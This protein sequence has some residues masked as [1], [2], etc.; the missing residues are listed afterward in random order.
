MAEIGRLLTAMVTPFAAD[1]SVDYQQARALA[2]ALI[3]SGSDGLIVAGTTGEAPTLSHEERL[4][5]FREV[6]EELGDRGAVV[7]GTGNYNTAESIEVT[8]EAEHIG[9]DGALLTVPY[10]NKPTQEGLFQHFKVIAESTRLPCI[11]Y[12][13]PSRTVTSMAAE[14][15]VRLSHIQNIVG[16]KEASGDMEQVGRIIAEAPPG[17]RVWSGNDSDI[18]AIMCMGGFGVISVAAHLVGKQI[19][20]MIDLLLQG[21]LKEAGAEHLR[22]LPIFKGLFVISNPMPVKYGVNRAGLRVGDPRL[23]LLPPDEKTAAHV[24]ALMAK[25]TIDLPVGVAR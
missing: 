7:A 25:Y 22:L 13:V 12:N 24:D 8:R 9:V 16:V 4:R 1:G 19:K 2:R 17:F 3:E 5:L 15:T 23:P 14:T 20:H 18:F 21:S 6:K 10:Y 11:V